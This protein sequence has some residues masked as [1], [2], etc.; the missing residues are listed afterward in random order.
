MGCSYK[1]ITFECGC[2]CRNGSNCEKTLILKLNR[3]CD[4]Y[5]LIQK[6]TGTASDVIHTFDEEELKALEKLFKM[7]DDLEDLTKEEIEAY[8]NVF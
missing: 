3:V 8:T 2:G 1:K 7:E 5:T 6:R 4:I